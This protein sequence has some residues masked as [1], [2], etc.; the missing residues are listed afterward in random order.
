MYNPD[1]S[2]QFMLPFSD[3]WAEVS[4]SRTHEVHAV[5]SLYKEHLK[6]QHSK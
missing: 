1:M 4:K 3:E 5:T 2:I 6:I